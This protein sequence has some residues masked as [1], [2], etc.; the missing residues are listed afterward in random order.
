MHDSDSLAGYSD[1]AK[2]DLMLVRL[3]QWSEV[4]T[5]AQV[6]ELVNGLNYPSSRSLEDIESLQN[7]LGDTANSLLKEEGLAVP[8]SSQS[9][10]MLLLEL[11]KVVKRLQLV[12]AQLHVGDYD[13]SQPLPIAEQG[14][15]KAHKDVR[16]VTN[17]QLLRRYSRA[18]RTLSGCIIKAER[19][20]LIRLLKIMVL[21]LSSLLRCSQINQLRTYRVQT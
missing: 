2:Y 1:I 12:S 17:A 6:Q 4:N 15:S 13:S 11:A 21:W 18:M 19:R 10:L 14:L 16:N 5:D 3:G 9:Y 7:V 8:E 20:L